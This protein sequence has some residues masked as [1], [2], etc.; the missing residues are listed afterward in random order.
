MK[1]QLSSILKTKDRQAVT[2]AQLQS[3]FAP[4]EAGLEYV[5]DDPASYCLAITRN[6]ARI[7][8]LKS[9]QSILPIVTAYLR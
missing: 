9:K 1:T 4:S 2:L 6:S 5:L 8:K 7:V 3:S